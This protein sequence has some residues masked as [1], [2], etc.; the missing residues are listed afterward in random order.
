M[1]ALS[2]VVRTLG[3]PTRLAEALGSL[4]AQTRRDFEVVVVDM[5]GGANDR[6]LEGFAGRLPLRVVTMPRGT[7]PKALNSGVAAASAP[8][9]GILDDDNLYDPGQVDVLLSGLQSSAADYVYTGVRHA[10][11]DAEGRRIGC[12]EVGR[13]FAFD[14]L[15]MGNFIYATGSA[16]RKSL[17]DRLGGYD[18]RFEVF[19]DWEFTIR[20]A[21]VAAIAYL[22][23]ISGESRKFTGIDGVS[24]FDL[25]IALVRRCQAG[26]YW[27]HRY[28][29]L[30]RR[31]RDAFRA[32]YAQHCARRRPARTGLLAR[33]VGGWRLEIVAD[34]FAWWAA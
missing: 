5:G 9:I 22:G 2:V 18:E 21:Q 11:Y 4:A 30:A 23:V 33:T 16:Y 6:V 17:W 24:T 7:R 29:Y 12:R 34:L 31:N 27:E 13:A 20:A 15:I 1:P 8:V 25:E 19:E 32:T 28:L 10:T 14:D 26:V 3:N